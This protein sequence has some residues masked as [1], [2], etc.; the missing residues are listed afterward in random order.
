MMPTM[1]LSM[2][3]TWSELDLLTGLIFGESR[4]ESWS[5]KVGVGLTVQTRVAHPGHWNWGY[6]WRDV[7]LMPKQFSCFNQLDPNLIALIKAHKIKD[8]VWLECA[9]IAEQVYL[10][11]VKDFVGQPTHYHTV[12]CDPTW[13]DDMKHLGTIGKH[14]FFTCF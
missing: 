5:G 11:R 13:D 4:S 14:E 7:I 1:T 12:N 8:A 9:M 3:L 2:L 10:G 6:N